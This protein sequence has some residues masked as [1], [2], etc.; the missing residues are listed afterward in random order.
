MK[1][2]LAFI[3][4][5][6]QTGL[7]FAQENSNEGE[8][9]F[10]GFTDVY[11]TYNFNQPESKNNTGRV[12]DWRHNSIS[13]GMIQGQMNYRNG[14]TEIVGDLLFGPS[15]NVANYGNIVGGTGIVIKQAY[16]AH[17]FNDKLT[18]TVG[19]YGT[20]MGYEPVES[21]ENVNYSVS[22]QF[23]YGPIYHTGIKFD[24]NLNEN[25]SVL[26]GIVNGWDELL[27]VNDRKSITLQ[28]GTTVIEGAE[29]Y[30]NWIG[31]DEYNS[32][33][34][35]GSYRGS[36]SYLFDFVGKYN[37]SENFKIGINSGYGSFNT[38]SRFLTNDPHSHNGTWWAA[39]AYLQYF[40]SETLSIGFRAEHFEDEGN[41]R[42]TLGTMNGLTF[43]LG[44]NLSE[45]FT[46]KPELRIDTSENKIFD[47]ADGDG[48]TSQPT[49]GIAFIGKF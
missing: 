48:N 32:P 49:L 18:M 25:W 35:F 40:P 21:T 26:F 9:N 4:F 11:Y 24:Y 7:L 47:T 30:L 44:Y 22:Y 20:H 1:Y 12:F 14:D 42:S 2:L 38:A 41:L 31:G 8:F 23:S 13:V 39:A 37:V 46:V 16:I 36:Y 10:K 15:G 29:L 33:A 34:N 5:L 19:Q 45:N 28:I 43:T 6:V 17:H 27:D 3:F